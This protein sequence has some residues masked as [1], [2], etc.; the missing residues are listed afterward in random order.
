[1]AMF[2][3]FVNDFNYLRKFSRIVYFYGCFSREDAE[4]LT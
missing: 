4:V 1:M 3:P 2:N